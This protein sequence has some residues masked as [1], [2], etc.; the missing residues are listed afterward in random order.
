MKDQEKANYDEEHHYAPNDNTPLTFPKKGSIG[1]E[2][3]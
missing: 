2:D 3:V 1:K